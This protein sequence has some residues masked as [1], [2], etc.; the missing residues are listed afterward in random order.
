MLIK[1]KLYLEKSRPVL[2]YYIKFG[3]GRF[4]N[5]KV[6]WEAHMAF[7]VKTVHQLSANDRRNCGLWV[8]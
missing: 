7:S 5:Q 1:V 2:D 3:L 4:G 8:N 6:V